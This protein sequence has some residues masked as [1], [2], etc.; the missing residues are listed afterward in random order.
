MGKKKKPEEYEDTRSHAD[1]SR[2]DFMTV[3]GL[4]VVGA[5][6]AGSMTRAEPGAAADP[7]GA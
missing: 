7:A 3:A 6:A 2:R 1:L 4:G 5:A